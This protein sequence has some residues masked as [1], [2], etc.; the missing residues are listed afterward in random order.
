VRSNDEWHF[1]CDVIKRDTNSL[2]FTLSFHPFERNEER[3]PTSKRL[4][5]LREANDLAEKVGTRLGASEIL[6]RTMPSQQ[7]SK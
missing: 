7:A 2:S 5:C 6:Q 1:V 3:K 4:R